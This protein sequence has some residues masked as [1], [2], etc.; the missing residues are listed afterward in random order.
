MAKKKEEIKFVVIRHHNGSK[1]LKDLLK[2]LIIR[3]I[4]DTRKKEACSK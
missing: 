2:N 3:E 4:T 1:T